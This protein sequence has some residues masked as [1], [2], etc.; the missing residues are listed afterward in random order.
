MGEV[1]LGSSMIFAAFLGMAY[2]LGLDLLFLRRH[3]ATSKRPLSLI[4]YRVRRRLLIERGLDPDRVYRET[5]VEI[6]VGL[7]R[8]ATPIEAD[9][10]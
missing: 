7:A 9:A 1:A 3:R 8:S 10:S 4:E 5:L 2:H 6:D